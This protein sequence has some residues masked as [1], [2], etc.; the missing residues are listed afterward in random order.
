MVPEEWVGEGLCQQ[1]TEEARVT[2]IDG[3]SPLFLY[4]AL[5]RACQPDSLDEDWD[6][7]AADR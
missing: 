4:P 2:I 5:W 6:W 3:D 1:F 7:I